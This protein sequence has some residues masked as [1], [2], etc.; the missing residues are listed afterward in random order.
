MP[1]SKN[2]LNHAYGIEA[3]CRVYWGS[4][5][6]CHP[7]GHNGPHECNCCE[8][9]DHTVNHVIE[10]V[11]GDMEN[12]WVECVAKPPY[13]GPDTKFYGEDATAL[14]LPGYEDNEV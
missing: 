6:C 3:I 13:Y 4:H 7:K 11:E 5:G 14:G 12:G 8:C 2:A 1:D 10:G 9:P